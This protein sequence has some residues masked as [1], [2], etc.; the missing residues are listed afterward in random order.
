M[1]RNFWTHAETVCLIDHLHEAKKLDNWTTEERHDLMEQVQRKL[2]ASGRPRRPMKSIYNRIVLVGT[3]WTTT[4]KSGHLAL[5]CYGW[6]A[7]REEYSRSALL[8]DPTGHM[9]P[10]ASLPTAS[11]QLP[12]IHFTKQRYVNIANSLSEMALRNHKA[13][14]GRGSGF[15]YV[16][17]LQYRT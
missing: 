10:E 15:V 12:Q 9:P 5:Y 7:L 1:G 13:A 14:S 4:D 6:E 11:S 2:E 8:S 16:F 3:K 17:L